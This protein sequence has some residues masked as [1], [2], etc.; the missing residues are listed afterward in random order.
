VT[1]RPDLSRAC[2]QLE[3]HGSGTPND[4]V[5]TVLLDSPVMIQV[6]RLVS[7]FERD[8]M[9]AMRTIGEH[10]RNAGMVKP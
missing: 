6:T 3:R 4:A 7:A 1:R 5:V 10:M 8:G 2:H 9:V